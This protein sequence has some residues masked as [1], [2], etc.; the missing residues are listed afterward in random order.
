MFL[1]SNK[2]FSHID[3]KDYS[4]WIKLIGVL[5]EDDFVQKHRGKQLKIICIREQEAFRVKLIEGECEVILTLLDYPFYRV[6]SLLQKK[7]ELSKF[8]SFVSAFMNKLNCSEYDFPDYVYNE[9]VR[10][11]R[12]V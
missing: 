7:D 8:G 6:S 2:K 9:Y 10:L 11:M 12:L 3:K 4:E 5:N 1:K